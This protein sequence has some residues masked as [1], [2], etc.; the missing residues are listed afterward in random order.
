M[1]LE[2]DPIVFGQWIIP[3]LLQFL[4][5]AFLGIVAMFAVC[6]VACAARYGPLRGGDVLLRGVVAGARDLA[7]ARPRRV[8]ALARLAV[9][10]SLRRR[11]WVALVLFVV[12]LIFAGW[13]LDP[14]SFDPA[15]LYLNFVLQATTYLVLLL[16]LFLS[17]FSLPADMKNR[18]IHTVVTKPA[19]RSEIFLG[20]LIGFGAIGATMLLVMAVLSYLF[21]V[22]G[23]THTHTVDVASLKAKPN[24]PDGAQTGQTSLTQ[25][26]SHKFTL[27]GAGAG[28]TEVDRG[29]WH[30]ITSSGGE[31]PTYTV[32]P[33]EDVFL[34]RVPKY[35][36]LSFK[37]RNGEPVA[38][39]ISVGNEW[40]YRSFIEG[41]SLASATWT[42]TGITP[43]EFPDGLPLEMTIRVFRSW[44]GKIDRGIYGSI[45]VRNPKTGVAS[46]PQNFLCKDAQIDRRQRIPLELTDKSGKSIELFRDLVTP[47]GT[48]EITLQ[49]LEPGQYFGMAKADLYLRAA[50]GSFEGNFVKG[51]IGIFYQMLLVTG[52]G[53]LFSTFLSAPVAM[54]AEIAA[55]IIGFCTKF[56]MDL[57]YDQSHGMKLGGGPVESLF[58]R[59]PGQMNQT[60]PLEEGMAKNVVQFLDFCVLKQMEFC[61]LLVPDFRD[62]NNVDHVTF[63]FD[64]PFDNLLRQGVLTAGYML[65]VVVVGTFILKSR[66]VAQ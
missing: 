43:E 13:F 6:Y 66:E 39:G 44:K 23:L 36:V 63:G 12:I 20:R 27:D 52:F 41:G 32:G 4:F 42:F 14:N 59:I 15:K 29:H 50:D 31:K 38:R 53:L 17:V 3:A 1:V 60:T 9:Q 61:C 62:F 19:R 18:T 46:N 48:V 25:G 56:I 28:A 21:V 47:E 7:E 40:A 37:D 64:I 5:F 10:E 54:L 2:T 8:H 65:A 58:F 30:Q 26:H 51:F 55:I 33:P 45:T 57:V 34:A 49:C 22:R 35:G 11:I 24:S 16:S